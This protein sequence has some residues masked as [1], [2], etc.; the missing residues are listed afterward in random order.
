LPSHGN[1][2]ALVL[3]K[4]PYTPVLVATLNVLLIVPML[5]TMAFFSFSQI[6]WDEVA[7]DEK[8]VNLIHV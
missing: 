4:L 7:L 5:P 2:E 6:L 8:N 1:G 3:G